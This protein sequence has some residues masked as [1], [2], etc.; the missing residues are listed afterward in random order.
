MHDIPT[1]VFRNPLSSENQVNSVNIICVCCF[2]NRN[3]NLSYS[4]DIQIIISQCIRVMD[5]KKS[6]D[7]S[8]LSLPGIIDDGKN[9]L[10]TLFFHTEGICFPGRV[11]RAHEGYGYC[12]AH[13]CNVRFLY[14]VFSFFRDS[15]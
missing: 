15:I 6:M 11:F 3:D 14:H 9:L 12:N 4:F 8:A 2:Y 10:L 1:H 7:Y 13:K 5:M